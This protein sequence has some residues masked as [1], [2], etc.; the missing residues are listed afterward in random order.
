MYLINLGVSKVGDNMKVISNITK[1]INIH[2]LNQKQYISYRFNM[3]LLNNLKYGSPIQYHIL[4]A[5]Y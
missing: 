2:F 4:T 3:N 1:I 5:T